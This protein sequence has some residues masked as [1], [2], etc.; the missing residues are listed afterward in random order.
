MSCKGLFD[1]FVT[2]K[3]GIVLHLCFSDFFVN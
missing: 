1:K 2:S 3:E